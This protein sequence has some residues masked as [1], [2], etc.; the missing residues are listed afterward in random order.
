MKNKF[1]LFSCFS[2]LLLTACF[3]TS[4]HAA[5]VTLN[6]RHLTASEGLPS[7]WVGALLQDRQGMIWIGTDRGLCRYDGFE[8]TRPTGSVPTSSVHALYEAEDKIWVGLDN[9]LYCYDSRTDS[10]SPAPLKLADGRP[11]TA[12]VVSIAEDKH[13]GLWISTMGQGIFRYNQDNG[14]L[15]QFPL[16][17]GGQMAGDLLVD[18]DGGIWAISKYLKEGGLV[19]YNQNTSSFEHIHLQADAPV[20]T[21][22]LS[23][24]Q[25]SDGLIW[26]G[27]WDNGLIAFDPHTRR[28][29]RRVEGGSHIHSLMEYAPG[30]LY[31]GSDDG[32]MRYE[33]ATGRM[34]HFLPVELDDRSINNQFVYPIL[35][36][37]E[38]G[39]W[40]G[41]Y[42]G[43]INYASPRSGVFASYRPSTYRNSLHGQVISRFCED[44]EGRIWIGSDDGG[45]SCFD[46]RRDQPFTHFEKEGSSPRN[47]HALC[48][49]GD[50]LWIGTYTQGI[51]VMDLRTGAVRH[52]REL[53][54]IYDNSLGTSSYMLFVDR[55]GT[56]WAG[57]F[58]GLCR[59]NPKTDRFVSVKDFGST[60][61]GICQDLDGNLWICTEG[62]GIWRM[63]AGDSNEWRQFR[64]I[65]GDNVKDV[66]HSICIDSEGNLWAGTLNGLLAFDKKREVF[67]Q[68]KLPEGFEDIQSIV[69]DGPT[70]WIASSGGLSLYQPQQ[71][72]R[73][74]TFS[75]GDGLSTTSYLPDAILRASDGRIYLGT[76]QGM[77]AFYPSQVKH[78]STAPKVIFTGLD[79]GPQAKVAVG[80][81]LLPQN[82]NTIPQLDLSYRNNI[83]GISFAALSY[84]MP[85]KN[86][87]AIWLEGFD[88]KEQ[89]VNFGNQH[90]VTYT[91]LPAGKYTLHVKA[92]NN[93][94]VWSTDEARLAFVVHPPF[95]W[96]HWSR[97]L[98]VLLFFSLIALG[99]WL[100][101]RRNNWQHLQEI[102]KL[103]HQNAQKINE[104][105]IQFFTTIAHEIRT[106]VSLIIAPLEKIR[107]QTAALPNNLRSDLSVID[108]NSKRLLELVNQLLD[109]RKMESGTADYPMQP[110]RVAA[111]LQTIVERFR[112]SMEE[113]GI[114]LEAQLPDDNFA[115]CLNSEAITKLVSNL[116][117][118]SLKYT[119][120]FVRL[121]CTVQPDDATWTIAVA[122]NGPG[123]S[124]E[125][126]KK[127]FR[128]FYQANENK[129][130]TGI[131]LTIV[132]RVVEAHLGHIR[133]ES[134]LGE[135]TTFIISLPSDLQASETSSEQPLTTPIIPSNEA[136][137]SNSSETF[138]TPQ[139]PSGPLSMLLVDD[140]EEML[141]FLCESLKSQYKL[142]T[143]TDGRQALK[144]LEHDPVS[145]IVSDWM[146][147]IMDGEQL[148]R[149]VRANQLTSHIP[150]I[151]LT[152]KTDDA[153]KVKGMNCGA[154]AYIE[155]P[156]SL[157]YLQACIDNLLSLR[158]MLIQKFSQQPLTP[159]TEIASTPLD[160][161]FLSRLEKLIEDNFSNSELNVD[162]L[163]QQLGISRSGFFAKIKTLANA[164]PNEMIQMI[165]LKHAARLLKQGQYRVSEVCYM[166]G[167]NSPSYFSKCFQKQF[168]IKPADFADQ[169]SS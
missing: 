114:R 161:D 54:D 95:Y 113:R 139:N 105:R 82:L 117:S 90:R 163:A 103:R 75:R 77:Q 44:R 69:A 47:I 40:V 145:L 71:D 43:G 76:T 108:R 158:A 94:N 58:T 148:C 24:M 149:A 73:I 19:R 154:D 59:Y 126:Q 88:R 53:L 12:L 65:T 96:N 152:A 109:F 100:T 123:I 92:S 98:Y 35:R 141:H 57:S 81:K 79:L 84:A 144:I 150:F 136:A 122:D 146:M 130:G 61:I 2:M 26:I 66:T 30:I 21:R 169:Q 107:K 1:L 8:F 27:T 135:G 49:L 160:S 80:S 112:A 13:A 72:G 78:N 33:T 4:L 15:T 7:N 68:V 143:A 11:I 97:T 102:Q 162:F 39:L 60:P 6:F 168:G 166:V 86:Q 106:P 132:K 101:L 14:Q 125:D 38:G 56:L 111:L 124:E 167:F 16:P 133:V 50:E 51:D 116:L 48:T 34:Q 164:S 120:D 140:N 137:S 155:K 17:D 67:E 165:R 138:L 46:P 42:Y 29:V 142:I 18:A 134:K 9:G 115:P 83:I 31:I 52:Y 153:S 23:M 89:W 151:M 64:D 5:E 20:D 10:L 128:P 36:D 99:I 87:F 110:C 104:A 131:G 129:P 32:M 55:Q 119:K 45:L 93:D 37:N 28:V 41:T 121:S 118:N 22:G 156:F 25:D 85:E 147:P 91:N 62:N 157:D 63:K 70:L 127:I 3:F 159:I 74:Q